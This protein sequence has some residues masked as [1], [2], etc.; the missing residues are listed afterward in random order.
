MGDKKSNQTDRLKI[1]PNDILVL[2]SPDERV[3]DWLVSQVGPDALAQA[4]H[5]LYDRR[6]PYVSN[7]AKHL[8]FSIPAALAFTPAS[9]AREHL[10][11]LRKILS[12][13]SVE[14]P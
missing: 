9:E 3:L 1:A 12:K 8:G 2:N 7:L 6:K 5:Q 13:G 10:Q 4:C 11:L 14:Q